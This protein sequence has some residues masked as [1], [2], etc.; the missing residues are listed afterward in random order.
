MYRGSAVDESGRSARAQDARAARRSWRVEPD[1]HHVLEIDSRLRDRHREAVGD[2]LE[3]DLGALLGPRRVLAEPLDQ[4]ALVG[5]DKRVVD[6][7]A[8]EVNP[9][10]DRP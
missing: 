1:D 10:D 6:G 7:R 5:V 2:L 8:A 3:A 4:P 9:R